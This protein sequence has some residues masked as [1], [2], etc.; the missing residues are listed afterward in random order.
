MEIQMPTTSPHAELAAVRKGFG[1][2]EYCSNC[3]ARDLQVRLD[4][5]PYAHTGVGIPRY[6]AYDR[7]GRCHGVA[8]MGILQML[9]EA[10]LL[11]KPNRTSEPH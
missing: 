6:I 2:V 8:G 5:E 7:A 3:D 10:G 11:T 1:R 4:F 9:N